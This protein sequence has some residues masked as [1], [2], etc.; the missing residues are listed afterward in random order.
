M[1]LIETGSQSNIIYI[2]PFLGSLCQKSK[3]A[4]EGFKRMDYTTAK[5]E[6]KTAYVKSFSNVSG[7]IVKCSHVSKEFEGKKTNSWQIFLKDG[8]DLV[9]VQLSTDTNV[10]R[11]WV[12]VTPNI[13]IMKH[14]FLSCSKD[15][16]NPDKTVLFVN[17]EGASG[18]VEAVKWAYT[19]ENPNGLPTAKERSS[20]KWD[21]GDQ[22]DF[23]YEKNLE[24]CAIIARANPSFTT[25]EPAPQVAQHQTAN[26]EV[27]YSTPTPLKKGQILLQGDETLDG[28]FPTM[29]DMPREVEEESLLF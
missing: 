21:Y 5:G 2:T 27:Q 20:G 13:D 12:K 16:E 1:A 8:S 18:K 23:L 25:N 24:F 11:T 4:R 28:S 14:V 17:Q 19:R 3:E 22:E 15:K 26:Q 6:A 10:A 9:C 29:A 7:Q